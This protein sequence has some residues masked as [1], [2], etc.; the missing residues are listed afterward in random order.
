MVVNNAICMG[1]AY[2]IAKEAQY[3][4]GVSTAMD[5]LMGRNVLE[6]SY[7]TG[8]G[9]RELK[10]PHHRWWSFQLDNTFPSAPKGVL[11]GGPNSQMQDPMIQG[12][13]YKAGEVAPMVCYL[14]N[15]EAWSVNECT[16]NW[17]SP[18]VWI[19]SFL[20][21]EAP[22]VDSE[23]TTTTKQTTTTTGSSTTTAT[24][25]KKTTVSGEKPEV[26]IGDVNLDGTVS[27]IDLVYLNKGLAGSITLNDQQKANADCV[28]DGE[29]AITAA[30]ATALMKYIIESID[31]LPVI[32]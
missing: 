6:Q 24:T 9:E 23:Q 19:A 5:Y 32:A 16:I 8:Y 21:D 2:D 30:D 3:N 4:S 11:S 7:V 17:N 13:G 31:S 20:E 14:D 15:V 25:T 26:L 27:L 12:K 18:L 28:A 22:L 29:G 1:L 10:Y